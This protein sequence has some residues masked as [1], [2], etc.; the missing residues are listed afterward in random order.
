MKS[1]MNVS[2]Y[3]PFPTV[4]LENRQ[5]PDNVITKA[6][7]WCGVCLRDGNQSLYKPMTEEEKEKYFRLLCDIGF[8][9][10]E[11][12]FP[13]ASV[14]DYEFVRRIIENNFIPEDVAIQVLVPAREDLIKKTIESLVGA[15]KVIIH[16]YYPTSPAQR[17]VVLKVTKEQAIES[18]VRGMKWIMEYS[19][20]LVGT[21]ITYQFSPESFSCT[22][23]GFAV[24]ICWAVM[25]VVKPTVEHK[26][27][28]NLP[29][30]MEVSTPNVYADQIEWFCK[31][32]PSRDKLIISVHTHNDQG[33]GVAATELALLAGADRVEGTLFGN[34]ERTGNTDL[35]TVALNLFSQGINPKLDFSNI[36][37]IR[38]TYELC[39]G[40]KVPPRHPYSGDLVFTAF[41]GT[42]QDAIRKGLNERIEKTNEPWDVPYLPIDPKDIGRTYEKVIRVNGQ[43]GKGGI[44]YLLE[45]ECAI[46]LPK[47]LEIDFGKIAGKQIDAL[48]REVSSEDLKGMFWKEYVERNSYMQFVR[49]NDIEIDDVTCDCNLV[50]TV[51][52]IERFLTGTGNGPINAAVNALKKF[53]SDLVDIVDQAEHSLREGSNAEAISYVKTAWSDGEICWGVGI[54]K[55]STRASIKAIISAMNRK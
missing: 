13:S 35:A 6:P 33:T 16:L 17:R 42:H 55:N 4:K 48:C 21:D 46:H 2:K 9:E 5:W 12:G 44:A 27:I 53:R 49:Y 31:E 43:S 36:M 39:T 51:G 26:I 19:K 3:R 34:G 47:D 14:T 50:V 25:E 20:K 23:W 11:V 40:M 1:T 37:A 18:A 7:I 41:S 38:K 30:T 8:K 28:L 22:E 29:A 24:N 52:G 54:D 10:I 45:S 15:K 32:I